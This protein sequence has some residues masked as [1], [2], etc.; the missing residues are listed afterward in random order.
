MERAREKHREIERP[1]RGSRETKRGRE[2]RRRRRK[3]KERE[4]MTG[5]GRGGQTEVGKLV[6][7]DG[8]RV[9]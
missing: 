4:R 3:R 6:E 2:M 8:R 9:S 7:R 1:M 5:G